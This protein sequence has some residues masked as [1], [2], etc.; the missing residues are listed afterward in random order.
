M[1]P[2]DWEKNVWHISNPP[3]WPKPPQ[4]MSFTMLSE[5]ESCSRRCAL[6]IAEYPNVWGK[7]GYPNIP[8]I[9]SIEGTVTHLAL[10]KISHALARRRCHSLRDAN[11]FSTLKDLGGYTVIITDC[12]ES[13]LRQYEGNPRATPVMEY[14]KLRLLPRVPKL[15]THVQRLLS[16]IH[17]AAD[18]LLTTNEVGER[19]RPPS[20]QLPYGSHTEVELKV[21]EMRWHGIADLLTHTSQSCEIRDFKSGVYKP[22]HKFQLFIYAL[23]WALDRHLNPHGR[24]ADKLVL[25][26]GEHDMEIPAPSS[27]ELSSLAAEIRKRTEM[28]LIELQHTPPEARPSQENCEYCIVRQLCEEYWHW[29]RHPQ[30]SYGESSAR[31]VTDLQ[32][33]LTAQHGPTSWDGMVESSRSINVG[34]P[35]LLR[36]LNVPF[37]L[38]A[39]Q[40]IR[41][42]NIRIND[43]LNEDIEKENHVAIA[44]MGVNTEVFHI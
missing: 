21:P 2:E 42:L 7:Q 5:L 32:I 44:S 33:R 11:A 14:V 40:R 26:Y 38:H 13:V 20:H 37:G 22:Q 29:L 39:G 41:L 34:Q 16:R 23:L 6:T 9:S 10:K 15:R 43:P 18:D 19:I 30:K 31:Y 36:T 17:L 25:S 1:I 3:L 28:A 8:R 12:I 24:I 4:W 27:S 35:I